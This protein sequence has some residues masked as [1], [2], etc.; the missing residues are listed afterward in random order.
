MVEAEVR[1]RRWS[2]AGVF[3][4]VA[5]LHLVVILAL[6]RA[7]APD[8]T[9]QVTRT[10]LSSFSVTVTTPPPEPKPEPKPAAKAAGD[11]GNAGKKAVPK[12]VTAPKPR[13]VIAPK[14]APQASSSGSANTS[15][16]RDNGSGTGAGGQ[17]NGTG[18]GG[19]GSGIGGGAV[20]KPVHVSGQID[21]ASDFPIPPG[22]REARVGK[23]V[24]L[25]LT[26]SPQGRATACRVFRPSGFP[27]TD[28]VACRLAIERLRFKPATNAA[29]EPVTG[30]FYW[31]QRFYF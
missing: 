16:S 29:G 5:L 19:S 12:E 10:V 26:I 30:T 2:R 4:A 14:P 11:A 28:Q 1:T 22:G 6:V 20:T 24:I 13:I 31:Q 23:S 17:G 9:A 7:F 27:D 21:R 25:A 3:V 18:A 8:F 15:G